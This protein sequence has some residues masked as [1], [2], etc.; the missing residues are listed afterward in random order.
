MRDPVYSGEY[1]LLEQVSIVSKLIFRGVLP[2]G[3]RRVYHFL[4]T[5][6]LAAPRKLP[7]VIV[8]WIAGLAMHDY[9]RRHFHPATESQRVAVMRRIDAMR[10]A[11][12]VPLREGRIALTLRHAMRTE[13]G[14]SVRAVVD[15][16]CFVRVGRHLSRLL[17]QTP[18]TLT[19]DVRQ[20]FERNDKLLLQLL[21]RLVRHGDRVSI[22]AD[23]KIRRRI[24]FDWSP[25]NWVLQDAAQ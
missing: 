5:L 20:L 15:R 19:L 12:A 25:F 7:L 8:D 11:I 1:G 23:E 16:R 17:E 21:R 22:V 4:R 14:I 13:I 6:P 10:R 24:A 18:S 9:V 2:G 3:P